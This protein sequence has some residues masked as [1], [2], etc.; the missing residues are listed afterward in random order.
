VSAHQR[1]EQ[2]RNEQDLREMFHG[3]E[4]LRVV[5]FGLE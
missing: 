5:A 1:C 3:I 4:M 2:G